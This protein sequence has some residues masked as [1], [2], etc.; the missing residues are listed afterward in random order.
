[1]LHGCAM[2][3]CGQC[4]SP[5]KPGSGPLCPY[6]GEPFEPKPVTTDTNAHID[7]LESDEALIDQLRDAYAFHSDAMERP[8][9]CWLGEG[10]GS[11][12][13]SGSYA[14][15]PL[16]PGMRLDD[17]EIIRE[18]G[19]GGMGIV[20]HARQVSLSRDVALK[21]LPGYARYGQHAIERFTSESRAAARLHHTH[22]VAI[23]AQG[24]H[25]GQ[26]YYAMELIDGLGLDCL[27]R[28]RAALLTLLRKSSQPAGASALPDRW[29]LHDYRT[30]A[31]WF[32]DLADALDHA[33]RCGV[34]HRDVKP[35]NLL[36]DRNGAL[37]LTDFGLAR[38]SEAPT[39]TAPGDIIGTPAYLSPEQIRDSAG[40]VDAR[41]DVY[42][43]GVTMYEV[44]T[45]K[46]PFAGDSR[47]RI[48]ARICDGS[49]PQLRQLDERIPVDL[50]TIC[51]RA[52]ASRAQ[53]RYPAAR[54][55]CNDLRRFSHRRRILT[56]RP[57]VF[58]RAARV[59]A[60]HRGVL[61][62][63]VAVC[64]AVVATL[65]WTR[66]VRETRVANANR[67]VCTVYDQLVYVNYKND[68]QGVGGL[69]AA[70]Q[71]GADKAHVNLTR[72]LLAMGNRDD[73]SALGLL[74]DV[75]QIAPRDARAWYMRAWAEW[76]SGDQA[77]ALETVATAEHNDLAES[78][79]ALFFKGLALH[80]SDPD[81]AIELYREANRMRVPQHGLYPQA[82]L[83]I[84]RARNQ[85]LY[86]SRSLESFPEAVERLEQLIDNGSYGAY[87]YY[88]L[89]IA[90]RLAA[91]VYRGSSGTRDG[92]LV[93]SHFTA[94]LDWARQGQSLEPDNRQPVT[95]EAECLESMGQLAA[96]RDAYER[97]AALA[98][99]D[100]GVKAARHYLWRLRY[101]TGEYDEALADLARLAHSDP[102]SVQYSHVYPALVHAEAGRV[103]DA[104]LLAKDM[105]G[106][107]AV[108]VLWKA[109]TLRLLGQLQMAD[110][111]LDA[112]DPTQ[113]A[114]GLVPPQ[115][116][117]WVCAV[118]N[119][120][121]QDAAWATLQPMAE[122]AHQ[123]WK[124][125]GEAYFHHGVLQLATAR[126]AA[127]RDSIRKAFR[128]YD[129]EM[130]YTYHAKIIWQRMLDDPD[131]PS[132][133]TVD[134]R[135]DRG[136]E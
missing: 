2:M 66:H 47:D 134:R 3:I 112:V 20:Y 18:L 34:V 135:R 105:P 8:G 129:S 131:W 92:A 36:V 68:P 28:D 11:S 41:T 45:G 117:V 44:L 69:E 10:G 63:V 52:M 127:A 76:R 72:A 95:A 93:E 38:L 88:L 78:A 71:S 32:A 1:M 61:V 51:G 67:A 111:L 14:P 125:W 19:R 126:D 99:S 65:G 101:W 75:I 40:P 27:V 136:E 70:L 80:F 113:C 86:V 109:T 114:G 50:E 91:E 39:L 110:D 43:L 84:A 90:H 24:E 77:A 128:S 23:H 54:D 49:Y 115:T 59:V 133:A 94:A 124:L 46:K 98:T 106:H 12:A 35:H 81:R 97:A 87:P 21:V 37:H 22:V 130:R 89:S 119:V 116:E 55:L 118:V 31:G 132:W 25:D 13:A 79:D 9:F 107:H 108:D 123:P 7:L 82:V 58:R 83:H 96:A 100:R 15:A 122:S 64:S 16:K 57:S 53:D 102:D 48:M 30:L 74:E 85:Q 29:A 104:V 4:A 56:R 6:C 73:A 60:R 33:H 26:Y 17:F 42:S 62:T 121:R 103:A 120:C 5:V